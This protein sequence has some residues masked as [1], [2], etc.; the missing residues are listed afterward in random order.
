MELLGVWR[1]LLAYLVTIFV[2]DKLLVHAFDG[3]KYPGV[4]KGQESVHTRGETSS[5]SQ[6]GAALRTARSG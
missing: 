3:E 5:A 1:L 6:N 4:L 2:L